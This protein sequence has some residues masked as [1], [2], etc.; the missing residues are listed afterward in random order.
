MSAKDWGVKSGD[1]AACSRLTLLA[2]T[3]ILAATGTSCSFK[4]ERRGI[5]P[6]VEATIGTVSDDIEQERYEKIYNE[7]SD[8]WREAASLQQSTEV[9]NKLKTKLGKV[10]NRV[11]NSATEQN[12]SGGPLKGRAFIVSYQTKFERGEGMETFTLV[13]RD[14][15]WLLARYFVNSTALN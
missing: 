6:E 12:N 11:L 7:A 13:E 8:L 1:K 10:E 5:P 14:H 9:L 3:L 15:K 2:V 4:A